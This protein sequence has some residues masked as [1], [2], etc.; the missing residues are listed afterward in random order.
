MNIN[1]KQTSVLVVIFFLVLCS[2][3]AFASCFNSDT[4]S[5][6]DYGLYWYGAN[7]QCEKAEPGFHNAYY[8]KTQPTV[9]YI[10]GWQLG[11]VEDESRTT[12]NPSE[13]SGPDIDTAFAWREKGWN[14][15]V[16]YWN[17]FADE[18]ELQDAEAKI[19]TPNGNRGMRW[20]DSSGNYNDSGL[21]QSITD[22]FTHQI[23]DNMPDFSGSEFR[24]AG[25]SLGSQLAL[26]VAHKL[27]HSGV[28]QALQP[29]RVVLLDPFSSNNAKNY[30][31]GEWVGERMDDIADE[32]KTKNVALE[33]YRSSA[34][35]STIFIGDSNDSLLNKT[36]YT[37]LLPWYFNAIQIA[38]KHN[39]AVWHYFWSFNFSAPRIGWSNSRAMSASTST[40]DTISYMNSNKRFQHFTGQYSQSPSDD[41][42]LRV[43][44]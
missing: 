27:H 5:S 21:S 12:F 42:M 25:H 35:A 9:I 31:G 28:S 4:F 11:S 15:G 16:L 19:W 38:E 44:K 41:R 3:C 10:H 7:Q 32:L 20:L 36:A 6:L 34:V 17:Q 8:D 26:G 30:L 18:Q 2:R 22:I 29:Q 43:N 23:L 40:K 24:L 33:S 14:I 39:A 1:I 37:E 13:S